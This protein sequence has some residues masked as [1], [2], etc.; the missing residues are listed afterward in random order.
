MNPVTRPFVS[1]LFLIVL[2]AEGIA[3]PD[4]SALAQQSVTP[5]RPIPGPVVP[6][7]FFR[8]ALER[9][10]RSPDG[11][12]GPNYWQVYSD[13]D[14]D[15]RLDPA[16]GLLSGTE[17]VRFHNRSPVILPTL[18]LFLH[19]NLHAE[20]VARSRPTEITGG[21]RLE[22]VKAQGEDLLPAQSP[23]TPGYV[24]NGGVMSIRLPEA[25]PAGGTVELEIEWSFMVPQNGG[26]RMGHSDREMYFLAYWFPKIA[27]FDDLRGWDAEPY[28]GAEFYEGYGDYRVTLTVPD[29]WTLM[30]TGDLQNAEEVYTSQTR[31][32]MAAALQADTMVQIATREDLDNGRV[33]EFSRSGALT[34]RFAAENVRDFTWTTSNVQLWTGTSSLVPD[35][36]G[37][38]ADDRVA[39]HSFW[40]DYRAPLWSEQALYA[41]HSIE[42]ESRFTGFSYPWPH[43][44][45]VE[46]VDIIGGGMEFPMFTLMGGYEGRGAFNLYS[47]TAHELAHM[48]VPMIVGS[49]EKRHAWMDEGSTSFLENQ[50]EPD[51]WPDLENQDSADMEAYLQ[52][53]RAEL[54]QSM[55]R[56][57][58]Y[59]EPGPA[60]GTASYQKPA[61]LLVTLRNLLGEEVF[62]RGYQSFIREWSFKHPAPWD[63]FNTF[64]RVSGQDL[65]WFWNSW[66]Y[67]TWALDQ[68]V[69]S[70]RQ[71][72]NETVITVADFGFAPMPARVRITT[73]EGRVLDREVPVTH[74]LSGEVSAEIR[75]PGSAG[76]V[77]RVE[78]DPDQGFPD[79]NRS[80]NV[81]QR[82]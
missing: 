82:G 20:G 49:N 27:V 39:I 24:E 69:E 61:T 59:Y 72:G 15:A 75:I 16:S 8:A 48:W 36:D 79:K 38:G 45:S 35:R 25:V 81:W 1:L 21:I 7:P 17:T 71:E 70:V 64:E 47:V 12:P 58:D 73:R 3:S 33:T 46:G 2:L 41:K 32:R 57:H 10:T 68:G 11:S 56:H 28:R 54:E 60:G 14:I 67:E 55:M 30:A 4:A 62:M 78:I 5:Q 53:A 6:P 37:D 19:Q 42:Y 31:A 18:G 34:Y 76:D 43:M 51:Y 66:Y 23:A 63:F 50:T 40:R 13:Y 29:G 74:W 65:D 80:N 52:V 77:T 9:G 44:T 26:G 22:R